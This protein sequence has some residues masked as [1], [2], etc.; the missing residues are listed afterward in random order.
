MLDEADKLLEY[1]FINLYMKVFQLFDR[2]SYTYTYLLYDN[3]NNAVVIDP[4]L[5]QFERD[6]FII[7]S[8]N[9]KLHYVIETH[10][11]ADHITSAYLLK[12]KFE[13]EI[14][15]GNKNVIKG[16]DI[17]LEDGEILSVGNLELN[18]IH[19]P[20]HT[21]GCISIYSKGYVFTGDTLF[22]KGAGRTD[23]QGGSSESSFTSIKDKL[24]KLPNDTVVYPAHNYEGITSSTIYQ[25]KKWNKSVNSKTKLNEYIQREL[26]KERPYPQKFDIAVPANTYCG[27]STKVVEKLKL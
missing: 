4:V 6:S 5:E 27:D 12:R 7:E 18:I 16:T 10:I 20:G 26:K 8:L 11:H 21:A 17:L 2:E 15:H 13:S 22:I 19:T 25:E 23:F 9:F 24:Y 3:E 1:Y 14:A